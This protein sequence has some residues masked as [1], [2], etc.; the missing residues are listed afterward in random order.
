MNNS[1]LKKI[2]K[3]YSFKLR[4]HANITVGSINSKID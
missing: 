3:F 1:E 4:N 2:E